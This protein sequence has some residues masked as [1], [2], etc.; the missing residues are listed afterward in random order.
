MTVALKPPA[1]VERFVCLVIN[2]HMQTSAGGR[3]GR[4]CHLGLGEKILW[5]SK[6]ESLGL[7]GDGVVVIETGPRQRQV[8]RGFR[9]GCASP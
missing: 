1:L 8:S 4:E 3:T 7:E 5:P 2:R 9:E 6:R